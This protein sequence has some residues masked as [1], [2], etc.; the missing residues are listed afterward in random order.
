MSITGICTFRLGG[1]L[2]GLPVSAVQEI[3][4]ASAIIPV[5]QAPQLVK[6]LVNLRGQVLPALDLRWRLGMSHIEREPG[7]HVILSNE[8]ELISLP[9]DSIDDV[10]N[11]SESRRLPPPETLNGPLRDSCR[12]AWDLTDE[13]LLELDP[14][15][16]LKCRDPEAVV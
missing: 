15:K 10:L 16:L 13:L 3:V 14:E 5:P 11:L 12:A 6:G 8:G 1:I 2:L 4:R 7:I 9:V